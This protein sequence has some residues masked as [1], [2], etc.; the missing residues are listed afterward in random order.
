MWQCHFCETENE[1]NEEI[2]MVCGKDKNAVIP[3]VEE[4]EKKPDTT[5]EGNDNYRF[6]KEKN[7]KRI[8]L[9]SMISAAA[10]VL[11]AAAA[12]ITLEV[13]YNR[14]ENAMNAGE[15]G[16]AREIY[17]KIAFYRGSAE[18]LDE[19]TYREAV[20]LMENKDFSGARERFNLIY[21]YR[22]SAEMLNECTYRDAENLLAAGDSEGAKDKFYSV[23]HYKDSQQMTLKCDYT[24]AQ[25]KRSAGELIE[26]YEIFARLGEYSDSRTQTETTRKMLYRAGVEKYRA[27]EYESAKAYFENTDEADG[28]KYL[29]LISAH[30]NSLDDVS[31]LYPLIGFE[32][33]T[34]ILKSNE[35]MV[36]FLFARWANNSG[37]Y[38]DFYKQDGDERTWCMWSMQYTEGKHWKVDNA[39]HYSGDDENGWVKQWKYEIVSANE[40]SVYN[41]IDGKTYTLYRQ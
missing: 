27:G 39:V 12:V 23:I 20:S 41:Y 31:E 18:M 15:Y 30:M 36:K 37:N 3:N 19:C 24:T 9:I 8:K 4:D 22:N 38:I 13:G 35:Y 29:K 26:A 40:I 11:A 33:T 17:S 25:Q 34:E 2:C 10:I 14:A 6:K 5:V 32:D 1:D 7:K 28:E 16:K 21:G